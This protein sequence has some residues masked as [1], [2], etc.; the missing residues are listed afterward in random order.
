MTDLNLTGFTSSPE[1]A[2]LVGVT[3]ASLNLSRA[4]EF[5]EELALLAES[6]GAEV[7]EQIIQDRKRIAA[8]H[9]IGRGKAEEIASLVEEEDIRLVIFDDDLSPVQVRNLERLIPCKIVDRSA[10]ILDI[11]ASR[12][13]SREAKTQVEL[14][15]L[16][17]M[18]PRLTRQWTHLSKQY[19]GIGTKGP[20]ETQIETDRRAIRSRISHLNSKLRS[21]QRER[22]EQRKGREGLPRVSLVGYTNAGKSTILNLFTGADVLVEDRL[23]A[24]LDSTVRMVKVS[25]AHKI[26]LSDTVGFIR[27]LPHSLIA[28]FRST[29]EEV[30]EADI[31]L[32]VVD[33]SHPLFSE[34][35]SVV[36]ETLGEIGAGGKPTI[37][38]YNKI[39]RLGDRTILGHLVRNGADA[40]CIS[41]TRSINRSGLEEKIIDL[42]DT[43][44]SEQTIRLG[45]EDYP[46]LAQIHELAEIV[47][48]RYEDDHILLRFRMHP[49]Y[50]EKMKKILARL[51]PGVKTDATGPAARQDEG[52]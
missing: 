41:A 26:L 33:V 34:H 30:R 27:K 45:H 11:F 10:L 31:L 46:L 36:N 44:V 15:Q 14:A 5:L 37:M 47:E 48:R 20:G 40:V 51:S 19:G 28:S 2:I 16:Q 6:A 1:R 25:P 24:T 9:F 21:I 32:H 23:F 50:A 4:R 8:A 22:T 52:R 13:R 17:Y 29:L 3:R 49:R 7:V 43:N 12:A 42:L 35:I 39:D 18:L 38:V